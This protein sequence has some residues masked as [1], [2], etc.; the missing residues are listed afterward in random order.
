MPADQN[1]SD[2]TPECILLNLPVELLCQ[3]I[4]QRLDA[5]SL[6][7][8][9]S[10]CSF[11]HKSSSKS[12]TELAACQK[13]S[14]AYGTAEAKRF[15]YVGIAVDNREPLIDSVCQ[16]SL[17]MCRHASWN[18]RLLLEESLVGFRQDLWQQAGQRVFPPSP[19][20]STSKRQR[21]EH[22]QHRILQASVF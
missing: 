5:G 12:L 7:H 10:T 6:A 13:L 4:L 14:T 20:Q 15:E 21:V 2:T 8:L 1:P 18:Q 16:Q 9:N 11:F 22:N 3:H 19:R 17:D